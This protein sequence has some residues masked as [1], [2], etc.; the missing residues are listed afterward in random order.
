MA[1][2]KAGYREALERIRKEA[3]GELV[4]KAEAIRICGVGE[5]AVM[6]FIGWHKYGGQWRIP[7]TALARA[8][9]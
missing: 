7:A 8:I 6:D 5:A 1:L 2:E 9:C 3:A 4:T